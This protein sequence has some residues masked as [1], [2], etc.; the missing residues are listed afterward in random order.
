MENTWAWNAKTEPDPSIYSPHDQFCFIDEQR[1]ASNS[2]KGGTELS[3]QQPNN[4]TKQ[5][6]TAGAFLCQQALNPI[7]SQGRGRGSCLLPS[8]TVTLPI[9]SGGCALYLLSTNSTQAQKM[10]LNNHLVQSNEAHTT[11]FQD[12]AGPNGSLASLAESSKEQDWES[13]INF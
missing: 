1:S 7:T 6:K 11:Q 5:G 3:L 2:F 10:S 12:S 9:E 13:I 8:E 4:D